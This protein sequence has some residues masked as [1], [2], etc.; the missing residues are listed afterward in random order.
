MI[1]KQGG[2]IMSINQ[3]ESNIYSG[4]CILMIF[5]F[6]SIAGILFIKYNKNKQISE[7]IKNGG[8]PIE[9]ACAMKNLS[10]EEC[11]DILSSREK[12]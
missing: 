10:I 9:I 3:I 8:D 5:L 7:M 12:K 2:N 4:F 1:N 6:F 11:S